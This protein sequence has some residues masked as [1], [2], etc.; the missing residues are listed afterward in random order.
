MAVPGS[1]NASTYHR[2]LESELHRLRAQ[3]ALTWKKEARNLQWLGLKDGMSVLELGSGPG[4]STENLLQLLPNS[5]ITAVEVD[6]VMVEQTRQQLQTYPADRFQLRDVNANDTG[7]PDHSQDFAIA[8]LLFQHLPEPLAVAQEVWRVLK[9]GG[10]FVITDVDGDL[11][12]LFEP[13]LPEAALISERLNQAQAQQGGDR[14]ISRKLWRLLQTAGFQ[15]LNL[16][17]IAAQSDD[18]GLPA[19]LP[20][21]DPDLLQRLVTV[22]LLGELELEQIAQAR[23]AFVT[24]PDPWV[25]LMWFMVSGSK[26]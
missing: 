22:G 17:L 23:E 20:Q 5:A 8:R 25:L 1:Y 9:P 26:V 4:F 11:F 2:D 19:F 18:L 24:A 15:T 10:T 13:P 12:W 7:L 3:L 6:P 16:E 21:L 14:N